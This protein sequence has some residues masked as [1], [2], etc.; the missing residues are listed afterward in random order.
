MADSPT[1]YEWRTRFNDT[2]LDIDSCIDDDDTSFTQTIPD[3]HE[4]A[5][6]S[7]DDC[8]SYYGLW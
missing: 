4:L 3:K 6:M 2:V 5:A 7:I 1:V 8:I